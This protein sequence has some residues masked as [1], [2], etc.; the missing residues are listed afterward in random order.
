MHKEMSDASAEF[1]KTLGIPYHVVDI[2]SVELNGAAARKLD[3]EGW[4]PAAKEYRELV[5]CSNCT[6]FQ[7]RAVETRFV[8]NKAEKGDKQYCH[9][10]NSTLCATTRTICAILENYQTDKG[11]RVPEALVP[12]VGTSFFPFVRLPVDKDGKPIKDPHLA[13]LS[14]KAK[15]PAEKATS[16]TETAAKATEPKATHAKATHAKPAASAAPSSSSTA[17]S[18]AKPTPAPLGAAQ[19]LATEE[20][21]AALNRT[22]ATQP[23]VAG[24]TPSAEDP[25]VF[26]CLNRANA[27]AGTKTDPEAFPHVARWARHIAS[28]SEARRNAL[29]GAQTAS[30][31]FSA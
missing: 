19:S 7:A 15:K 21:L 13:F 17:K 29:Q 3:L 25:L 9:F 27:I 22:L 30:K 11:V 20:G 28:F 6:D 31:L 2:V 5:S 1:Y 4:F 18:A 12:Y 14:K 26:E 23:Y 10:L 16:T 24:F 8:P